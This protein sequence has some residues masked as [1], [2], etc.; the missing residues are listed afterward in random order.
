MPRTSC[1]ECDEVITIPNGKRS[2]PCPACG[3]KITTKSRDEEPEEEDDEEQE[4]ERRPRKRRKKRSGRLVREPENVRGLIPLIILGPA[5][6]VLAIWAPFSGYGTALAPLIGFFLSVVAFTVVSRIYYR[7]PGLL[8]ER[9]RED[10]EEDLVLP[11]IMLDSIFCSFTYPRLVAC[12]ASLAYLGLLMVTMGII[13]AVVF[14][15]IDEGPGANPP[16]QNQLPPP[17]PVNPPAP[18]VSD[19]EIITKALADLK[20]SDTDWLPL[21]R[22]TQVTNTKLRRDAV[23]PVLFRSTKAEDAIFRIKAMDALGVWAGPNEVP[24]IILFLDDNDLGFRHSALEALRRLHDPRVIPKLVEKIGKWGPAEEALADFGDAAEQA[25]LPFLKP[26]T[27]RFPQEWALRVIKKVGTEKSVPL[28]EVLTKLPDP[29]RANPAKEAL[30][31]V[32][33]RLKNPPKK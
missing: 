9:I 3:T 1:P 11:A 15:R 23:I 6:L 22:L 17:P 24:A 33:A 27:E 31:E 7:T 30:E 25:L 5:G 13:G 32:N 29:Y 16:G 19:D 8:A 10:A 21:F 4:E 12:W 20:K 14:K 18:K 26:E 2:I 28:L